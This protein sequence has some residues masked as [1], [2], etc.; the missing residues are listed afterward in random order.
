MTS[1]RTEP[2]RSLR[3]QAL[4]AIR[5]GILDSRYP[6]GALLSENQLAE[7]LQISR[8]PIREALRE[9]A[10]GGLVRIL[11]QRGIVVSELSVHDIV[12]V[13]Q[14]REQLEGFAVRIAAERLGPADAEA[15]QAD[16]RDAVAHMHA[17]RLRAAYDSSVLMHGRI[18]DLAGNSRLKQFMAQLGD[19]VHRFGLLTLRHGRVERALAE[20]GEIIEALIA[21][22][23]EAAETLMRQHLR[24]DRDLALRVVLPA[25]VM[26]AELAG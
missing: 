23:P 17:G 3:E 25:G 9:L 22:R 8:T 5:R 10:G 24:A 13:Y 16:H 21:N 15:M 20:H 4:E 7:E 19:Q 11:P 14:L 2:P 26:Q 1:D 6:P 18:L 12:E